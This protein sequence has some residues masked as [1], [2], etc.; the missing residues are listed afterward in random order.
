MAWALDNVLCSVS[1]TENATTTMPGV[2]TAA[3]A[4]GT[5]IYAGISWYN[6]GVTI[7]SVVDNGVGGSLTWAQ[8]PSASVN[9]TVD[10]FRH[11]ALYRAWAPSGLASGRTIT[12]TFSGTAFGK[13]LFAASFSGGDASSA[14]DGTPAVATAANQTLA[15]GS[16]TLTDASSLLLTIGW[17]D[18][19]V[20]SQ[21][22]TTPTTGTEVIDYNNFAAGNNAGWVML[23]RLPGATGAQANSTTWAATG[24]AGVFEW[25]GITAAFTPTAAAPANLSGTAAGTGA[26]TGALTAAPKLSGTAAGTGAATGGLSAGVTHMG[27]GPAAT[28]ASGDVTANYA[29]GGGAPIVDDILVCE[30]TARDNVVL[31]FPAGWNKKAE[32]N[33]GTGLRQTIAWRRRAG[34]DSETSVAITHT[35]GAQIIARVHTIRGAVTSG[36]PFEASAV[37]TPA[38][39]STGAFPTT[40][41]LTA[42]VMLFYA[43]SYQDD[44]AT[45]PAVTNAQG[46]TLTERDST[47]VP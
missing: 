16:V 32:N 10:P 38:A 46:L 31:T 24:Q 45:A 35:G 4:A 9:G 25:L 18:G 2:T 21:N 1:D 26:T 28:A 5:W 8:V 42:G 41:T 27:T 13:A 17:Y 23:R 36:D 43:F 33:N 30:V 37:A 20:A 6:S 39:A 3:A 7:S 22:S 47:E 11:F 12:P 40:T 34:G 15:P 19:N 14:P 44:F 29:T